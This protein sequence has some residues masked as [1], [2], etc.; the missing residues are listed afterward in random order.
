MQTQIKN[1][2]N[3]EIHKLITEFAPHAFATETLFLTKNQKTA[4][5]VAQARG[6]ILY[7]AAKHSLPIFEYAPLQIKAAITGYG[8]SDK[9]QMTAMVEQLITIKKEVI[10]DDEYDAIAIGLTYF[11]IEKQGR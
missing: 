6:V 11:A 9:K 3:N 8:K 5:F 1:Q 4:I 7:E 2:Y 10:Y